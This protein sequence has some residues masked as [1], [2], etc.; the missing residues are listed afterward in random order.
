MQFSM[1]SPSVAPYCR[2][3]LPQQICLKA[4]PKE[5]DPLKVPHAGSSVLVG[6]G[7]VVVLIVIHGEPFG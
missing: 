7:N 4:E 5:I 1:S 2:S 3:F 6:Q